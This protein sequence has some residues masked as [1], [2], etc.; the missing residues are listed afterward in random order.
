MEWR[1]EIGQELALVKIWLSGYLVLSVF[2]YIHL[3]FSKK[4]LMLIINS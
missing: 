3:F 1:R 4:T 2:N